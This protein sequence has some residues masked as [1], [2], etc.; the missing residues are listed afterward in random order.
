VLD[1]ARCYIDTPKLDLIGRVHG[2][3]GYVRA[4]G[5]G[6]FEQARIRLRDWVRRT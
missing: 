6:V 2:G 4:A 1:A 5:P 3:G